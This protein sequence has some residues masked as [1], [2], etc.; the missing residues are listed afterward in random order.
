MNN[1]EREV[2]IYIALFK[3]KYGIMGWSL[4]IELSWL[5]AMGMHET[6]EMITGQKVEH[7]HD[8]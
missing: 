3:T 1:A 2:K 7:G 8:R 5:I 4:D 6:F